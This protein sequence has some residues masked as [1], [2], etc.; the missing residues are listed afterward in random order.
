[1]GY[2]PQSSS[3]PVG[4]TKSTANMK[5]YINRW[6]RW[7]WRYRY[8]LAITPL[9]ALM[10]VLSFALLWQQRQSLGQMAKDVSSMADEIQK[11][12]QEALGTVEQNE[13]KLAQS[14]LHTKAVSITN[15]LANLVRDPL[16]VDRVI[17][18][19]YYCQ[20]ACEDPN[21]LLSYVSYEDGELAST[22]CNGED[23]FIRKHTPEIDD[24]NLKK[25]LAFLDPLDYLLRVS[26]NIV[27]DDELLGKVVTIVNIS[28]DIQSTSNFSAFAKETE[29]LFDYIEKGVAKK[30]NEAGS[31]GIT[32]GV[33]AISIASALTLAVVFVLVELV[34]S[35][36][37]AEVANQ[38]KSEF[39]ANMSHEI[40][41]PMTAILGFTEI[42]VN[43]EGIEHAPAHRVEAFKTIERNGKFLIEIINDILDLSKIESGKLGV[44]LIN[45]SPGQI[46]TEVSTLMKVRANAK[47]LSL[48]I[49]Y[50]GPIPR[51]IRSDPIRLRQIF[52]NLAGNAIKFTE[53]G[54][55]V[56]VARLV[57]GETKFPK[58]Q[59]DI[60]D[61]GIGMTEAQTEKVFQPFV[62]AETS[63]T[64]KYGG[65]GLGLAISKRLAEMLGGT[66]T[67]QSTYG[68]GSTFSITISTGP[69]AGVE[70]VEGPAEVA[71]PLASNKPLLVE[72]S[73]Q[74][75]CRVLLAEDG[76]DN[77]RLISFVL[78][79]AGAEM[80]I[81]DNGQIAFD[82]AIAA[83]DEGNPF[84]VILMDMQMP[85]LDGYQ[86]TRR[87]RE[88]GYTQ[89][90]IALTAHA[91]ATD[92]QKCI[93]A[94]CDDYSIKPIDRKKLIALVSQ[95]ATQ[96]ELHQ[97]NEALSN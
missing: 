60:V 65:T 36:E 30:A 87:L 41:T 27:L 48:E 61:S 9:V 70:M 76:P 91:M 85:V 53:V 7:A 92:R 72:K 10:V 55:I 4:F 39:L 2:S 52:I 82:L 1:M 13:I 97:S 3:Q 18:L 69:L 71:V 79:K 47:G 68:E 81:A 90:I 89:P 94:G 32:I 34:N 95:Y 26:V 8:V 37:S 17:A 80:T 84:G 20:Q 44:E 11:K 29:T 54:N 5:K 66:I 19:D 58:M 22:F 86:A 33:V 62:Q 56:F 74:L 77:Q 35:R 50:E 15:I 78:K 51:S 59:F 93:D 75:G 28:T 6:R 73:Q 12:Q 88:E 21:I 31:Q 64:R 24:L 42:L 67:I 38:A 63:T 49:R 23:D 46:L 25:V 40:R 96:P 14:A 83:R 43:E 45:C 57:D 16:A